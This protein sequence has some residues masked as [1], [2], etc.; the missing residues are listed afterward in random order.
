MI[1]KKILIVFIISFIL[2]TNLVYAS[3]KVTQAA[4]TDFKINHDVTVLAVEEFNKQPSLLFLRDG[5]EGSEVIESIKFNEVAEADNEFAYVNSFLRFKTFRIKGITSPI[6]IALAIQPSGSDIWAEA[7]LIAEINGKIT[8]LNPCELIITSQDVLYVG[9]INKK[10]GSGIITSNFQW[11]AAHYEPHKYEIK[12]FQWNSKSNKLI[13][14][15][16]F[17]TK[18]RFAN[19]SEALKFNGLPYKN[20]RDEIV[21]IKENISTLGIESLL[22]VPESAK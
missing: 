21:S 6:L 9:F 22:P 20:V 1:T 10:F 16:K 15:K 19:G 4:L 14:K 12:I 2:N 7:K 5:K 3:P 11:D 17:I 8:E 13:L 18:K